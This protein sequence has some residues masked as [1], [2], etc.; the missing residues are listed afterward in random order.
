MEPWQYG[1]GEGVRMDFHHGHG[2]HFSPLIITQELSMSRQQSM[3]FWFHLHWKGVEV[4][5]MHGLVSTASVR[6]S[7]RS[8]TM[9]TDNTPLSSSFKSLACLVSRVC[10]ID[11]HG[12]RFDYLRRCEGVGKLH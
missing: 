3:Q 2:R 9:D 10:R 7:E 8:F 12:F 1:V 11:F 5:L 6:T 4:P